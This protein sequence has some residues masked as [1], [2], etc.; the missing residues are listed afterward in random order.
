MTVHSTSVR[1][2]ALEHAAPA[3]SS[4]DLAITP[5]VLLRA[6]RKNWVFVIIAVAVCV[7]GS[8]AYTAQQK[9]I[10]EAVATLQLDP[11]RLT[12][13]GHD[14][15]NGRDIGAEGYWSNQE[16]FATQ[17]QVLTSRHVAAIV[18]KKLGLNRDARFIRMLPPTAKVA[19]V[20]LPVDT[21][22]EILRSRIKVKPAQDSR[23][24]AVRLTDADPERAQRILDVVLDTYVDQN[25]DA[26]LDSSNKTSVWLDEQTNRLRTELEAQEMELHDFK[27][28]YNLLSVSYDDQSNMLRA[29]IQQLNR[30]LAEIKAK[31]ENIAARVAVLQSINPED[32]SEIPQNEL[33]G[34]P[35]L[36]DLR[37]D[38]M[39]FKHQRSRAAALG[40]GEQH[41]EMLAADAELANARQ[42]LLTELQNIKNG[43]AADLVAVTRELNGVNGLFESAK[44]YA[45]ELNLNELKFSRLRR[46]KENT[47][48]VF[49]LVLER[50]T[51]SGLSK[52]MPFN[53]VRV[54]DRP[55]KPAGPVAPVPMTNLS[56]GVALGLL[57][58]LA[59][60]VGREVLD[61]SVRNAE[62]AEQ[63]LG[64]PVLGSLPDLLHASAKSRYGRRKE[65]GPVSAIEGPERVVH[66]HPQ[67]A[68]AEA[69]RAVR[70]NLL[71]MS[72][73][74][75]YRVLLVTSPGPS[76]GKT[77]VASCIAIAMAQGGQRVCLVDCD[78]RRP[79]LH[80]VFGTSKLGLTNALLDP[81]SL[82]RS[83]HPT[84][85][86]NLTVLGSGPLPPNPADLMHSEALGKLLETLEQRFDR[87]VIDSPPAGLVT[88]AVIISTRVDATLLV[89]RSLQTR[90]DA[91]RRALRALR[92]VGANC[93]GFVLN[94]SAPVGK[95]G[96]AYYEEYRAN[97]ETPAAATAS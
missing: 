1:P 26:V 3:A 35:V 18:V 64:I 58:G 61:R 16:Y 15:P 4:N 74:E 31:K 25:L 47:E 49:S 83:L 65:K 9:R 52:A 29:E 76:E 68:V 85:I 28:Q 51:E 96:Y 44:K 48:R 89:V 91:A 32:P 59:G 20:E 33:L 42:A 80:Q 63:E 53:N 12:P 27:K 43:V 19:S 93:P 84:D 55:L 2:P 40:K 54:L 73:D 11:Q 41:P 10:Y 5:A 8:V 71:F 38:Y 34:S 81:S 45:L 88:D 86:P 77:T 24:V 6:I 14:T 7:G 21:A 72:P 37:G 82:E 87:I 13:L 78:L 97:P 66:A 36:G 23:L 60:A 67:S 95:D 56:F 50:S 22:A 94:A 46:S 30:A 57:L 90:R 17:H 62:D 75:P 69:A 79:R 39:K 70:T 92:G